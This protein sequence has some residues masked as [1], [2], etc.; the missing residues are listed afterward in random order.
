LQTTTSTY[1]LI[2]KIKDERFDEENIHQ[3]ALLL[4]IGARDFQVGVVDPEANRFLLL[5]DYVFPTITSHDELV[6][7]LEQ[8]FEAHAFLKAGFWKQ[9]TASIK[10]QNFVQ[11]PAALFTEQA[12]P[13]YL[14]FNSQVNQKQE[15]FL[16]VSLRSADA[17]T[18]FAIHKNLRN[19]LV[20]MYPSKTV[21]FIHQSGALIEATMS[22]AR[23]HSGNP[24]YIYIDRFKIHITSITGGKLIFYNQFVIKQFSDYVKYIMMVM[25]SLNMDQQTSEV[26]LWGYLGNNSPHYHE[27]IKYIN[28]VTFGSRPKPLQ[29][30]Y[31]FD[32][33]QDHH[34]FDLYS[35]AIS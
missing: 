35:I 6:A 14:K 27:F 1:K 5:E 7:T 10:N 24:L 13:E 2:K 20:T 12:L 22:F 29:F 33:V 11:V 3:Y 28:N 17:V 34:Y 21:N 18:V 23:Q 15:D 16:P 30:S 19:W 25:K 9:I 31:L 32:E 26:I 4:N 8:L